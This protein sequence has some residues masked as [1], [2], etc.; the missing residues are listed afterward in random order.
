MYLTRLCV[1]DISSLAKREPAAVV[2]ALGIIIRSLPSTDVPSQ[3]F[4]RPQSRRSLLS[5]M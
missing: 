5:C 1:V 3:A 2:P 4:P